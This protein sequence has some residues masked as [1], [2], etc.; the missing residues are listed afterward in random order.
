MWNRPV[1]MSLRKQTFLRMTCVYDTAGIRTSKPRDR[2]TLRLRQG[3]REFVIN[4]VSL[5]CNIQFGTGKTIGKPL[6]DD[7]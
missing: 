6:L 3:C 2:W 5:S 7:L 4:N 1:P